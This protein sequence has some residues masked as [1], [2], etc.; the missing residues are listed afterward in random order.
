MHIHVNPHQII[1][2]DSMNAST[3]CDSEY[4]YACVGDFHDTLQIPKPDGIST[5]TIRFRTE[6]FVGPQVVHCHYVIHE[7]LGCITYHQVQ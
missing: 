5:A 2:M 3:R 4:G 1:S 7:D 6:D